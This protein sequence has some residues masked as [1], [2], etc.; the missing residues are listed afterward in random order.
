M[1]TNIPYEIF[2]QIEETSGKNDKVAIIKVN[3][4]NETFKS[5][6][7]F[8]YDDMITTGLSAKKIN[9]EIKINGA[10]TVRGFDTP[11]DIM[12]Y[13]TKFNTGTDSIIYTVQSYLYQLEEPYR[14]FMTKVL[15]KSY[16]CGIT[17]GSVNKA[18]GKGFIPEFKVQLAHGYE[19]YADKTGEVYITRK[20]DGHRVLVKVDDKM[21]VTFRTRKGHQIFGLD[22][23]AEDIRT[24]VTVGFGGSVV[25]DGEIT[26]S[27]PS[28]PNDKI[29]QSTSKILK[30]DG[31]KTGLKFNVFDSLSHS[32]FIEGKSSLRYEKRRE[33]LDYLFG[34]SPEKAHLELVDV[35]YVGSDKAEI[36]RLLAKAVSKGW[37]GLM[38]NTAD[39]F[40]EC[41]RT[42]GLLKLKEFH[43][44]DLL[45]KRVEEGQ[46]KNAG[47]LGAIV[48]QYKDY[49]VSCGSGFTDDD[50]EYYWNNQDK[51]VGS[52]VEVSYFEQT[53]N[54]NGT[55]SLRFPVFVGIRTD[56]TEEDI[57]Y[58]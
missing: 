27:D 4:G 17:S 3:E 35:L 45:C 6:L 52:I 2:K 44:A 38:A 43:T 8:L 7:K 29:F 18:L 51:I 53:K 40:Y 48:L 39:G 49:E 24:T 10:V 37:E 12:E 22:E 26:V 32:D 19:K 50:R 46:G 57:S 58:E 21:N 30:K 25:L 54:Q 5:F 56:K 33:V 36:A 1:N 15:T 14:E 11:L 13:L 20:L 31:I 55:E 28:I 42:S 16:K 34:K 23:I 9:K 47:K 41:K